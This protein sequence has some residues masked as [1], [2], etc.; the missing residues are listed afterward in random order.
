MRQESETKRR[1][2]ETAVQLI[3]ESSYG[4][5]SVEDIC[6]KAD[7]NKGSF[8]YAFKSKSDLAVAAFE[9]F[10]ETKRP[11]MDQI[12]STQR[13]PLE[14]LAAYCQLIVD[15]QTQRFNTAGKVLGCPFCS[16][17][18]EL[19]TQDENIRKKM[20]ELSA[21]SMK[22]LESL[23]RDLQAEGLIECSDTKE[24]TRELYSYNIGVMMQAKIEN[25]L[26]P[27]HQLHSGVIRLLGAK[28]LA[29]TAA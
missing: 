29:P 27:L 28:P 2:L 19:S 3:W 20:E 17:G 6:T 13:P 23:V 9:R 14:R 4:S 15:D 22:Y 16:I 8:Y 21:R 18:S 11:I 24:M 10:W 7:V 1:I 5:V 12:F 26:K 25:D